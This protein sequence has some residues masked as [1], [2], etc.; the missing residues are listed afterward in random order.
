VTRENMADTVIADGWH[1]L[2]KV[3]ANIPE[4]EWPAGK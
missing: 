1:P 4:D 3:Y 2:E